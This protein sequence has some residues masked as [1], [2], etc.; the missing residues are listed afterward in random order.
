MP[1]ILYG[2][3]PFCPFNTFILT[4]CLLTQQPCFIVT[5]THW[6]LGDFSLIFKVISMNGGWG[7]S[8]EVALRRMP[9]DLTDE[10]STLV[11]VMAW[12]RQATSHYL[13][14]C[15]PRS[16][17]PNGVTRPQW[18]NWLNMTVTH[19]SF[20]ANSATRNVSSSKLTTLSLM[21]FICFTPAFISGAS[22]PL[23]IRLPVLVS[24]LVKG[25][26]TYLGF[27]KMADSLQSI[28]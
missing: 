8:Y 23:V 24:V 13:S 15:W 17:S 11:Q 6:P 26:L 28:F 27:N 7:I 3:H 21:K 16:M 9:L 25:V 19:H 22:H 1:V 5:L 2:M 20:I 14:Q 12:C 10:K 4:L 18:V